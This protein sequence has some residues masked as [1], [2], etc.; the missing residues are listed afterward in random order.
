MI[1][2]VLLESAKPVSGG[3]STI[4]LLEDV[5]DL[6]MVVAVEIRTTSLRNLNVKEPVSQVSL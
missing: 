2:H 1:C 5:K 3:T 4:Q 6:F